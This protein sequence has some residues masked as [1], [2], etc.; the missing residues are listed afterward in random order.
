MSEAVLWEACARQMLAAGVHTWLELGPGRTQA[1]MLKRIER[2]VDVR[3]VDGPG[4]LDALLGG[5]P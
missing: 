3:S 1:G 2:K 5:A 4:G